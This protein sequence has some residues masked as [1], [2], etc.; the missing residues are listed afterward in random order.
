M[1]EAVAA[2]LGPLADE[3][4]FVGGAIV[5]ILVPEPVAPTIRITGDVDCV[6][7]AATYAEYWTV[8]ERLRKLGF[9][10]C[11]DEDAPICRWVVDG[12]RVD[13]MPADEAALGL[14]NDWFRQ[15]LSDA[16]MVPLPGGGWVR[17]PSLPAFLA[18]KFDAF[19]DRGDDPVA[20]E[21]LEDIVTVLGYCQQAIEEILKS[22]EPVRGYLVEQIKMLKRMPNLEELVS[23]CFPP[24][25]FSQSA[26]ERVLSTV[27]RIAQE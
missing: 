9:A 25:E 11:R 27:N 24:D 13:V 12:I 23:G 16:K 21:D 14:R 3:V 15:C 26:A 18:T 19:E 5:P 8:S 10:E 7:L 4:V 1:I 2:R 6:V 17:I 20:D 22:T